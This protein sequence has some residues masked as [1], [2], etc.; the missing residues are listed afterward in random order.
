VQIGNRGLAET[1]VHDFHLLAHHELAL[2]ELMRWRDQHPSAAW[3]RLHDWK[4]LDVERLLERRRASPARARALPRIDLTAEITSKEN[5]SV[6]WYPSGFLERR[7]RPLER[8]EDSLNKLD[9]CDLPDPPDFVWFQGDEE[10]LR[11]ARP[12][13]EL[14]FIRGV[15]RLHILES[16]ET[17][18]S[19]YGANAVNELLICAVRASFNGLVEALR[20]THDVTLRHDFQFEAQTVDT[21]DQTLPLAKT[22]ERLCKWRLEAIKIQERWADERRGEVIPFPG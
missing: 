8:D 11:G 7:R 22:R 3:D 19:R 4:N 12:S 16:H 20:R 9:G 21:L 5:L 15:G 13:N 17:L 18:G 6:R 10:S 2:G 1:G 14:M